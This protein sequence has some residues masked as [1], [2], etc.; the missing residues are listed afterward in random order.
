MAGL[1][2]QFALR[3]DD[4]GQPPGDL[5][6]RL[7]RAVERVAGVPRGIDHRLGNYFTVD[8]DT[9]GAV[10]AGCSDTRQRGAVALP[11]F[12]RETCGTSF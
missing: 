2:I 7:A 12:V 4:A 3:P 1:G 9:T 8:I 6:L 5:V 11:A 10:F